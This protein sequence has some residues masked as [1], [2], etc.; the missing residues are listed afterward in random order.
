M[1]YKAVITAIALAVSSVTMAA[2]P[3]VAIA[4][5][6]DA[7][8]LDIT[9]R[10]IGNLKVVNVMARAGTQTLLADETIKSFTPVEQTRLVKF[11]T[12]GLYAQETA[13][14]R[15]LAASCAD[16][17][18]MD[19]LKVLLRLTQIRYV[20]QLVAQGGDPS[21]TADPSTMTADDRAIYDQYANSDLVPRLAQHL[22]FGVITP[23][24]EAITLQAITDFI[25]WR[26]EQPA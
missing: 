16:K 19:E 15:K 1:S 17:F 24:L 5:Q 23:D 21:L 26:A 6:V 10:I 3:A 2:S 8:K 11:Y 25:A 14:N 12:D 9:A 4:Q 22:D 18:T 7:A 20:Q 13:L